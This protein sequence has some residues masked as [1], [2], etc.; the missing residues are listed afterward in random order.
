[1]SFQCTLVTPETQ[2]FDQPASAA[3][4]PAHDGLIGIQTDHAPILLRI[5]A[6]P[7]TIKKTGGGD[8][9]YF[10]AGGVAQMKDNVLTIL[11]DEAVS[12]DK[13]DIEAAK[14]ELNALLSPGNT[15][16]DKDRRVTRARAI[17]RMAGVA[18]A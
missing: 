9:S 2:L 1:M 10:I 6:G 8:V 7:L 11:T 5:G 15:T 13:L 16:V 4:L 18:Q 12:P 3:T 14:S 17:L